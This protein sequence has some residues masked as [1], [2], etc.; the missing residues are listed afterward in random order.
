MVKV[1]RVCPVCETEYLADSGR[2]KLG[3]QTTCSRECSYKFRF[4]SSRSSTVELDCATCGKQIF[5]FPSQVKIVKY[6]NH[7]CSRECH[8]AGRSLGLTKRIVTKPYKYTPE[9]KASQIAS[10]KKLKGKR[11]HHY[12]T[13]LNCQKVFDC[14]NWGRK[15]RSEMTFCSLD[16]CN[17]YR[18]GENNPAWRG[19]YPKYYGPDWRPLQRAARLR[20]DYRCQRCGKDHK[21]LGRAPDVHH[22]ISVG[23]FQNRNDANTMDNVVCLCHPCHM[24]VEWNGMDFWP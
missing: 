12:M 5:K 10:A 1:S 19:G 6:S 9:G 4:A 23:S 22:I 17:A 15:R 7:F 3:R 11:V 2:L 14:P 24:Y 8:Y 21:P 13:C 16:C 18:K 20:D